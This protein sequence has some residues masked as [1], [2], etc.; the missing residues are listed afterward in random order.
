LLLDHAFAHDLVDGRLD[1]RAGDGFTGSIPFAIV[2]NPRAIG[3]NVTAELSDRL[4]QLA[5]FGADVHAI[6]VELDESDRLQRKE[7]VTVPQ[8]PLQPFQ[9]F[10]QVSDQVRMLTRA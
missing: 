9:L 10:R 4:A 3:P 5:L 8:V 1:E 7:Y 6:H 2:W